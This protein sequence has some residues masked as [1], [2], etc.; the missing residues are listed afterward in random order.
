MKEDEFNK[1][2]ALGKKLNNLTV[3]APWNDAFYNILKVLYSIEEADLVIKMPYALSNFD[4]V[5]KVTKYRKE[6]LGL[7]LENLCSK[8]LVMDL[9]LNGDYYYIPSPIM[10]GIFELTMMRTKDNN[11]INKLTNI[12]HNYFYDSNIYYA[13]NFKH[14]EKIS[15]FRSLPYEEVIDNSN[16]IEILDY[17][18][19]FYLIKKAN[20]LNSIT[21]IN[22]INAIK[23][24]PACN[25]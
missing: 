6:K 14:G 17:E 25:K 13:A 4:R 19:A 9:W 18:K 24:N 12:F 2:R 3:K 1:Y 8:G 7:I 20:K 23:A 16:S 11:N 15:L 5:Q 10:I 22:A 21:S